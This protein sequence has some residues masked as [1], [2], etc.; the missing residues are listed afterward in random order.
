MTLSQGSQSSLINH[1]YG[2]EKQGMD[3]GQ[4]MPMMSPVPSFFVA[5]SQLNE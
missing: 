5:C 2:E 4:K 1:D 3:G